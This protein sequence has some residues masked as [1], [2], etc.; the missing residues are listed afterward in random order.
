[1]I[2]GM[3]GKGLDGEFSSNKDVENITYLFFSLADLAALKAFSF[4]F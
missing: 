1:M 2:P 4:G 3:H